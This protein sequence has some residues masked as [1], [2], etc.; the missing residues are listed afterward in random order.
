MFTRHLYKHDEAITTEFRPN[1]FNSLCTCLKTINGLPTENDDWPH[2]VW[3]R[4]TELSL[5][6]QLI[7]L[8]D[9]RL[10]FTSMIELMEFVMHKRVLKDIAVDRLVPE[11]SFV[12]D[13]IGNMQPGYS[14]LVDKRNRLAESQ[15]S[16]LSALVTHSQWGPILTAVDDQSGRLVQEREGAREW[17]EE[18]RRLKEILFCIVVGGASLPSYT[19]ILDLRFANSSTEKRNIF[20]SGTRLFWLEPLGSANG[21][22]QFVPCGFPQA[23][24][25]VLMIYI[26]VIRPMERTMAAL[27]TSAEHLGNY[28]VYLWTGPDGRWELDDVNDILEKKFKSHSGLA[29][30]IESWRIISRAVSER[31]VVS[32]LSSQPQLMATVVS[33]LSDEQYTQL[34]S[35]AGGRINTSKLRVPS[36]PKSFDALLWV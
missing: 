27:F 1:S 20:C 23:A 28:E 36:S 13:E 35:P 4:H 32:H 18:V 10:A 9:L 19:A 25:K 2:A 33:F 12:N 21:P 14:F 16:L 15:L 7:R 29:I 17:L 22:L 5:N 30:G 31:H 6:G 26:A 3:T 11:E 24:E 8:G 34:F